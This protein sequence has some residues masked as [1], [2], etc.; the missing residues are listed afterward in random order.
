MGTT[1]N[2]K[3]QFTTVHLRAFFNLVWRKMIIAEN[4][5]FKNRAGKLSKTGRLLTWNN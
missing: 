5:I 1:I 3:V 4:N 2:H